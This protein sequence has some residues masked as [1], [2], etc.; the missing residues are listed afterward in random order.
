MFERIREFFRTL[1]THRAII[2]RLEADL[3]RQINQVAINYDLAEEY[4]DG[5]RLLGNAIAYR[6]EQDLSLIHI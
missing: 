3:R 5:V 2:E 1:F 4:K 6:I